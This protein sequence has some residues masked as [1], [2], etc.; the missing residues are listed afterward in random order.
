MLVLYSLLNS[1]RE[2]M[3]VLRKMPIYLA[4]SSLKAAILYK[5][6]LKSDM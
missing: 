6:L 3:F 1:L 5:F 4:A 2:A